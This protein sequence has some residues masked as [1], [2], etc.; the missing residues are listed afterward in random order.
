[1][2][3]HGGEHSTDSG[4]C[5]SKENLESKADARWLPTTAWLRILAS[6]RTIKVVRGPDFRNLRDF[7]SLTTQDLIGGALVLEVEFR[8]IGAV[9]RDLGNVRLAG[10]ARRSD[11][12]GILAG[13]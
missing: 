3:A 5:Q 2:P 13:A 11:R 9:D 7:G 8:R 1:M 4:D 10:T 6:A 12:Y